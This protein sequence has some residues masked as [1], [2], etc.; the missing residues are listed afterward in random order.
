[1]GDPRDDATWLVLELTP[2]GESSMNSGDLEHSLRVA[3]R[4]PFD[5]PVFIPRTSYTFQGTT[6]SFTALEGYV[7]VSSGVDQ[8]SLLRL[9][10]S[11]YVKKILSAGAGFRRTFSTVT[12]QHIR[13][14][15]R[16]LNQMVGAEL[17]EGMEVKVIDGSLLGVVGQVVEIDGEHVSV[18]VTMRSLNVIKN[19]PSFFLHPTDKA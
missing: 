10:G 5:C 2:L 19:F 7:F 12:Q 8:G 11:P 3:A 1:V 4:L 15:Q 16:S 6:V 17:E 18:L 14:L 9:E 13:D